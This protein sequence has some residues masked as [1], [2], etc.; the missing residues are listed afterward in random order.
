MDYSIR[1]EVF[2]RIVFELKEQQEKLDE[3]YKAGIDLINFTGPYESV[4]SMLIG[5]IYGQEGRDTFDWWCY[6]KNFGERTDLTMTDK[7]GNEL[8]RT[9]EELHQYLEENKVNDYYLSKYQIMT[10][11]E[12]KD[13]LDKLISDYEQP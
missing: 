2:E 4:I 13:L 7:D 1:L 3:V 5:S 8:C 12:K 6:E 11:E 10:D 9:I